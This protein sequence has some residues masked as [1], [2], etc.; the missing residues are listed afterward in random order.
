MIDFV[1]RL[2]GLS[3]KEAA[4]KLAQDFGVVYETKVRKPSVRKVIRQKSEEQKFRELEQKCFRVLS[5]YYHLLRR[6]EQEYAPK[7]ADEVWHPLFVEA[8]QRKTHVEYLLDILLYESITER[9]LLI[10]DYG[11]EVME[12]EQRIS[13]FIHGTERGI[14]NVSRYAA[15]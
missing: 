9:A 15:M 2:Y 3:V 6:W 11:K 4:E 8:V 5:D 1:A 10:K 7:T 13:E 14:N 12:L